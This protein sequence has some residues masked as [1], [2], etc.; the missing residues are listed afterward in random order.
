MPPSIPSTHCHEEEF[1]KLQ[2]PSNS[3]GS[4]LV[5]AL[6]VQTGAI[7]ALIGG[8]NFQES[9]ST[10]HSMPGASRVL[11]SNLLSTLLLWKMVYT[12]SVVLDQPITLMTDNGEWRL[13]IMTRSSMARSLSEVHL[14][15][16]STWWQ[17]RCLT[18]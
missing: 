18:K 4:D 3:S 1:S 6:D 12:A 16:Q 13:K 9:N 17:Y 15:N 2:T 7:R 5:V 14:V 8:R 10:G 11:L